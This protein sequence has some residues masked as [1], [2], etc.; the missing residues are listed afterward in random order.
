MHDA[1]ARRLLSK[2]DMNQQNGSNN[3]DIDINELLNEAE[4]KLRRGMS[5]AGDLAARANEI[6]QRQPGAVI[7]GVAVLGFMT[8]VLLRRVQSSD[9][10]ATH[11]RN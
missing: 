6:I 8:G 3:I 7:V 4:E 9:T 2:T 5:I 10:R 1:L 11:E